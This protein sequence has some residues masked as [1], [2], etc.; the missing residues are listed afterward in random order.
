MD[1]PDIHL[2]VVHYKH[3]CKFKFHNIV[4]IC[5]IVTI[6]GLGCL[7]VLSLPMSGVIQ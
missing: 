1:I 6:Q 3:I 2:F 7:H 5:C 4:R